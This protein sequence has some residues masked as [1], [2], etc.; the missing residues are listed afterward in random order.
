MKS[1]YDVAQEYRE[2][3]DAVDEFCQHLYDEQFSQHF[4]EVRDLYKRMQSKL[5]PI[6]DEELEYILTVFPLELFSVS[7]GLTKLRLD[8][9]VVK[10]KNKEKLEDLRKELM[11]SE[12][13]M[14]LTKT[15]RQEHLSHAISEQMTEYEILLTAYDSVIQRVEGEQSFSRELIMG[16]KKIWDSRRS[17]ESSNPVGESAGTNTDLPEYT[18]PAKQ[19]QRVY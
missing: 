1:I 2:D 11:K 5:Q 3:A 18:Y 17:S 19:K 8:R 14:K 9:E 7:E 12:E 4:Q 16:S 6:T 10:L 13:F 15:D